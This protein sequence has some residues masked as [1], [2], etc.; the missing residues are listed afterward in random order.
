MMYLIGAFLAVSIITLEIILFQKRSFYK[1]NVSL[2]HRLNK[3]LEILKALSF[4]TSS[5]ASSLSEDLQQLAI[6]FSP[7]DL[8]QDFTVVLLK[9]TGKG[10]KGVL[11]YHY[12]QSLESKPEIKEDSTLTKA[13]DCYLNKIENNFSVVGDSS[14]SVYPLAALFPL[15]YSSQNWGVLMVFA[16]NDFSKQ[17]LDFLKAVSGV[18]V[19]LLKKFEFRQSLTDGEQVAGVDQEW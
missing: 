17:D 2:I 7:Q 10:I 6:Y 15:R 16:T 11:R 8:Y 18:V 14:S 3:N 12:N 9:D 19:L 13:E 1:K 4:L 5:K